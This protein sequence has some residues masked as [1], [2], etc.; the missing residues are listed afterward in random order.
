MYNNNNYTQKTI[1]LFD[2]VCYFCDGFIQFVLKN[3]NSQNLFFSHLQS[4]F[5]TEEI[6]YVINIEH[7]LFYKK[8]RAI[9]E[10]LIQMGGLWLLIGYLLWFIPWF[11]RDLVYD[12]IGSY[13]YKLCGKSD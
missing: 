7:H 1:V 6:I 9:I 12:V 2:G 8:S 13:R 10:V 3:E 11:I 5:Y 4:N